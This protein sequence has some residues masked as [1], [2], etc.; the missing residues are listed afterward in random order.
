[1]SITYKLPDTT[2]FIYRVFRGD[3]VVLIGILTV[4]KTDRMVDL[5]H[6]MFLD[7]SRYHE[8]YEMDKNGDELRF[9]VGEPFSD[10]IEATREVLTFCH[11]MK[12][13]CNDQ[14][15]KVTASQRAGKTVVRNS[16]GFRYATMTVAATEAGVNY[17]TMVRHVK[18]PNAKPINGETYSLQS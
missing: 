13:L 18:N 7:A 14:G 3:T 12:P 15:F 17:S 10:H 8:F 5:T 1:M 11:V 16:D 4:N 9:E 2:Y 6:K